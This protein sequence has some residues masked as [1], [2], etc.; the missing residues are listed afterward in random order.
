MGLYVFRTST[1]ILVALN[2]GRGCPSKSISVKAEPEAGSS[3]CVQLG[4]YRLHS[5]RRRRL[6][7]LGQDDPRRHRR[8]TSATQLSLGLVG[9][10][11]VG[12]VSVTADGTDGADA[13]A[14]FRGLTADSG[15]IG[16]ALEARSQFDGPNVGAPG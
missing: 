6:W 16:D 2:G 14:A 8:V 7:T 15:S 4:E 11:P 9:M 13:N 3:G 5:Q 10:P 1:F 12:Q